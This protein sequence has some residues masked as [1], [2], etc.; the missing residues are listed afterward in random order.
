MLTKE[1]AALQHRAD[2]ETDALTGLPNRR[3]LTK[4]LDFRSAQARRAGHSLALIMID[5]DRFKPFNDLYGH[6]AGDACLKNVAAALLASLRGSDDLVFR[7]GG[8]EFA[9]VLP[10][11]NWHEVELVAERLRVSIQAL[12]LP[13]TR[14]ETGRVSISLGYAVGVPSAGNTPDDLL[15]AA[16][17]A[18]Y[19]AKAAG[20]DRT[21]SAESWPV[22]RKLRTA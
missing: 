15:R 3:S 22:L 4:A 19:N 10:G 13:H 8:E 1:R 17:R 7:Y 2:A 11:A 14:S 5:V 16:D 6:V 12:S 9:V 18:L 20:R 21:C